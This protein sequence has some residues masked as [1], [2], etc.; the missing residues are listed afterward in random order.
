MC[1][2]NKSN[3]TE[4]L[5]TES[6]NPCPSPN[7][8]PQTGQLLLAV[9][10]SAVVTSVSQY[11]YIAASEFISLVH[12]LVTFCY[13]SQGCSLF[14]SCL[15]HLLTLFLWSS[16]RL[17]TMRLLKPDFSFH[18]LLIG[19]LDSTLC[20]VSLLPPLLLA[21]LPPSLQLPFIFALSKLIKY[22]FCSMAIVGFY[23]LRII[24]VILKAENFSTVHYLG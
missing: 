20:N 1:I 22:S 3:R 15:L 12:H 21:L 17:Q 24:M 7:P 10:H 18:G 13:D 5:L 6:K 11:A 14:T 9:S 19:S 16:L 23:D 4:E 2:V 8:H